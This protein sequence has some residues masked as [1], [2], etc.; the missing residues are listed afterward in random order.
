M[1][2]F[3]LFSKELFSPGLEELA[4]INCEYW[5]KISKLVAFSYFCRIF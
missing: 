2:P 4:N 1:M 5:K 3:T